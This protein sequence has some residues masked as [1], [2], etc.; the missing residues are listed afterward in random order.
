VALVVKV[1]G[2]DPLEEDLLVYY[3]D[4]LAGFKAP[5]SIDFIDHVPRSM[6]GKSLKAQLRKKY[7]EGKDSRI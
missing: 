1:P 6:I 4:K 7:W 2:A 3:K 5:K